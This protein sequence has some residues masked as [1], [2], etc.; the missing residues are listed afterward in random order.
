MTEIVVGIDVATQDARV[1]CVNEGGEILASAAVALLAPIR[2]EAGRAEQDARA[3]W[4]AVEEA[5]RRAMADL[6]PRRA[7]VVAVA[8]ATTSGTLVLVD[9][10][11]EPLGPALLYDDRR[12]TAEAE[13]AHALGRE[14]WEAAAL[15]IGPSFAIAKLAWLASHGRLDGAAYAWS[16]ADLVVAQL[17]GEP[18][19]TDWSHA[20]KSGYDLV[21]REWPVEVY[22]ALGVPPQLLPR[23]QPPATL[24]GCVGAAAAHSTG[25]PEGCQVRLGMTDACAAQLAAGAV[26]P[27]RFVS[28]LGT[29]LVVKGTTTKLVRDPTGVV[30]SHLHPDGWWLPGGASNT[31]GEALRAT[32]RSTKAELTGLDRAAAA[33]GPAGCVAYPLVRTGERF[34]FVAPD[35]EGFVVGEPADEIESYRAKLEGVAFVERLAYEHLSVLGAGPKGKIATA[36]GAS[37]SSVWNRIRATVLGRPLVVPAHPTSAFGAALLAAAGTIHPDLTAAAAAMVKRRDEVEPDEPEAPALEQSYERFIDELC[38]RG[39]LGSR[40]PARTAS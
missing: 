21:R 13:R 9:P 4:P 17:L 12:A 25:L 2:P 5:L 36:G 16:A 29:T 27:G 28:V 33:R 23:V 37:R 1:V 3:W 39:W 6:G 30:Y 38:A 24:A 31:G 19:P 20:L 10:A 15:R 18:P 35:A 7:E 40:V 32:A 14:R 34:P 8:A 26:S 22:E 11:G